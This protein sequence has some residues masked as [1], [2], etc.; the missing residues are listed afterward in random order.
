MRELVMRLWPNDETLYE[1][2]I[3]AETQDDGTVLYRLWRSTGEL[4]G[5]YIGEK[6]EA[7][8]DAIEALHNVIKE[9]EI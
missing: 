4:T 6:H 9:G 3:L 8:V 7:L 2:E 5:H 1:Y